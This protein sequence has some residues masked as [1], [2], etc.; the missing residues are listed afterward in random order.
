MTLLTWFGVHFGVRNTGRFVIVGDV[1]GCSNE[2]KQLLQAANF[3]KN[4]DEL[5]FVGDLIG[6]GPSPHE[7]VQIARDSSAR[8]VKGNHEYNL[9]R[10]RQR[11]APLPDPE[12][13][14]HESYAKTVQELKVVFGHD[15]R[16]GL[17][18][19]AFAV[20]LD[21][22]AVYGDALTALLLPKNWEKPLTE[23]EQRHFLSVQSL[24]AYANK[25][26]GK[27]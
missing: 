18:K 13:K 11:G 2:L 17:Q 25:M 23:L 3:R 14:I 16:R 5:I 4:Q 9:L 24:R 8:A 21:T 7:V 20:G 10:W 27:A 26:D 22:G 19:E 12:G 1:H 6:K 15:A